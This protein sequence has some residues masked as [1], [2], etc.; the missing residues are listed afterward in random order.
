M[1]EPRAGD[2]GLTKGK[3]LPMFVIR[4]GTASRYGHACVA[5]G[6]PIPGKGVL[7]VEAMPDGAR[8]RMAD[9]AEFVWSNL[10]LSENARSSIIAYAV[11]CIGLPYDWKAIIGFVIRFWRA[12]WSTGSDDRADDKLICSELVAWCYREA[13]IDLV[14]GYAPGDV[15]PGDLADSLFRYSLGSSGLVRNR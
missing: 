2:F 1:R 10:D 8:T 14:P 11:R 4:H 3:G 15:S 5:L 7:I 9:P 12:K 13:G 6:P